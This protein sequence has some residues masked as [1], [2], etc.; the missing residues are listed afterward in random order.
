MQLL[1]PSK[2]QSIAKEDG[3]P[4]NIFGIT[5]DRRESKDYREVW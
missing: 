5:E 3:T 1:N 2:R 4:R